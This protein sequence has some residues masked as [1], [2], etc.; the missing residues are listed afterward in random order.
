MDGSLFPFNNGLLV[1]ADTQTRSTVFTG[2]AGVSVTLSGTVSNGSTGFVAVFDGSGDAGTRIY[3]LGNPGTSFSFTSCP[4]QTFT[5]YS[6]A[7]TFSLTVTS[8]QTEPTLTD[9]GEITYLQG[10]FWGRDANGT[11][12]FRL[13]GADV[14]IFTSSGTWTK[15]AGA[16]A[17]R[18]LMIG[19]GGG[20]GTGSYAPSSAQADGGRG[21]NPGSVVLYTLLP[22]NVFASTEPVVV[23]SGGLSDLAGGD[24]SFS[25][26]ATKIQARGGRAPS[27]GTT[28]NYAT[29][30]TPL[31]LPISA[32]NELYYGGKANGI[33]ANSPMFPAA[34]AGG[35]G[36][37]LLANSSGQQGGSPGAAIL[38][39]SWASVLGGTATNYLGTNPFPG[40]GVPNKPAGGTG[41][42]GGA[43]SPVKNGANGGLYG[44]GGGGGSPSRVP[45]SG[46]SGGTGGQGIVIVVAW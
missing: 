36:G 19:G 14:Q 46:G 27:V 12:P 7:S 40:L 20:G 31:M 45:P 35:S 29:D 8:R 30:A 22:A 6:Y 28:I 2:T 16:N 5:L 15:P 23:G 26:G 9:I 33:L 11:F 38:T 13:A 37:T 21:G 3:S 44:G 24:S 25:S 42:D 43:G 34:T 18:I 4:G 41:G 17:V 32:S 1:S 10:S 39:T